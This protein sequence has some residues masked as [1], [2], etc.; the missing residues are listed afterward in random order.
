MRLL[1]A[2]LFCAGL[3]SARAENRVYYLSA[4]PLSGGGRGTRADPIDVSTAEK[5][6]D[7]FADRYFDD[8][9]GEDNHVEFHF[10][11]GNYATAAGIKPASGWALIGSGQDRTTITFTALGNLQNT[12]YGSAVIATNDSLHDVTVRDLTIDGGTLATGS[13]VT[14]RFQTPGRS[15][16]VTVRVAD[17]RLFRRGL[18]VYVQD[19]ANTGGVQTFYGEFK[20]AAV[21]PGT[22]TLLNDGF[23]S[24]PGLGNLAR[25]G[26]TVL[27][28]AR[29]FLLLY[30][31]TGIIL[32]SHRI[33]IENVTVQDVAGPAYEGPV[34][35]DILQNKKETGSGN[36][37]DHCTL[38]DVFGCY[39]WGIGIVQNNPY[40]SRKYYAQCDITNC[41]LDGNGYYQ[42]IDFIEVQNSTVANNVIRNFDSPIFS[43]SGICVHDRFTGNTFISSAGPAGS[44]SSE[45]KLAGSFPWIDCTLVDNTLISR[46]ANGQG[47]FI[48]SPI[49]D[50]LFQHNRIEGIG[51]ASIEFMCAGKGNRFVDNII[52]RRLSGH[53]VQDSTLGTESGNMTPEHRPVALG[54]EPAK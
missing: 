31:R 41:L 20:V 27:T 50:C 24:T 47:I 28:S 5:L 23:G 25:I 51:N 2:L 45:F 1:L 40:P 37:I 21:R 33:H 9:D 13:P 32:A 39:G 34:G 49:Y 4:H 44:G 7:F 35:F 53:R 36:L 17:T 38:R 18:R 12:G 22:L 52:D 48:L 11:P 10:L 6:D 15:G 46:E 3:L 14:V 54:F 19:T 8:A 43:D 30:A 16:S 42:G 26:S 29:V